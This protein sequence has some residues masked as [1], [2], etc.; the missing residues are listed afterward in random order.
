MLK[1]STQILAAGLLLL[2][3]MTLQAVQPETGVDLVTGWKRGEVKTSLN[4]QDP[5]GETFG[6]FPTKIKR[7]DVWQVGLQGRYAIPNFFENCECETAWLTQF[8]LRGY[9]YWGR[10]FDGKYT[11]S[12][13]I[14]GGDSDKNRATV[15]RGYTRD[16]DIALGWLYPWCDNLGFGP[17]VGYNYQKIKTK[18]GKMTDQEGDEVVGTKNLRYISRFKGPYV[19]MDFV[20][21]LCD[22]RFN[23]G[24][25]YHMPIWSGKYKLPGFDN[26]DA[27]SNN[28]TGKRG[29]GNVGY[30]DTRY[31]FCGCWEVGLG[32]RYEA[33]NSGSGR[34]TPIACEACNEF[35]PTEVDKVRNKWRAFS[36]NLELALTY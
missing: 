11:E 5:E 14:I 23:F 27:F 29:H 19:G 10:V 12:A 1:K 30:L 35:P 2:S 22:F 4:A 16:Y 32:L 6:F 31:H 7:I 24:Y 9:A 36:I 34:A 28:R 8:Y 33:Y 21:D 13:T 26:E 17:V 18:N 3:A 20:Y 25:E 15:K